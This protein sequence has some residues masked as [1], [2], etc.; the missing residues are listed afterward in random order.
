MDDAYKVIDVEKAIRS[1]ES[2]LIKSLPGFIIRI[3]RRIIREDEMNATIFRNRHETGVPFV[4]SVLRDWN[5]KTEIKGSDNIPSSGRFIFV[6]NHP[7]GGID[8]LCFLSLIH[9]FYQDVVFPSNELLN[10]IPQLRSLILGINVF[11]KNSK[12]TILKL[13]KLFESDIQ[14]MIFPAGEV[15]RR[16]N[17][18]ISDIVWQKTFITKAVQYKRDIIPVHISGRNTNFFYNLS[19]L[20]KFLRIKMYLETLLLPG[21]MFKQRNS[22]VTMSVG[23]VIPWQSFTDELSQTEWA[24]NVKRIVYELGCSRQVQSNN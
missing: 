8:A 20:R 17:G 11:G 21:E 4:N 24:Q 9:N 6:A 14:I 2:G 16:K 23:K 12:E 1:S 13:N 3:I 10:C 22:T 7:V 19:N 18:I 5:V 15:S